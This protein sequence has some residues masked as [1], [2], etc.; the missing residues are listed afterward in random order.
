MNLV[1]QIK[2]CY[3]HFYSHYVNNESYFFV[4]TDSEIKSIKKFIKWLESEFGKHSVNTNILFDFFAVQFYHYSQPG[5]IRSKRFV[6]LSHVIGGKS[7]ER[8]LEKKNYYGVQDALTW[9]GENKVYLSDIEDILNFENRISLN[10]LEDIE[11]KRFLN[12]EYGL[13]NCIQLTSGYT[14]KSDNCKICKYSVECRQINK[15]DNRFL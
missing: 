14:A 7:I 5:A 8:W 12:T 13:S 4:P 3:Q 1:E 15:D 11:R 6:K 9:C 10:Q 2:L